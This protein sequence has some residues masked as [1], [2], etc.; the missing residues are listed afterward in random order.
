[1]AKYYLTI[2]LSIL[3]FFHSFAG[4]P[5]SVQTKALL[6]GKLA[7]NQFVL[8][9][10]QANL[11]IRVYNLEGKRIPCT[12]L[13]FKQLTTTRYETGYDLNQGVYVVRVQQGEQVSYCKLIRRKS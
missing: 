12:L 5:D 11:D 13:K 9:T 4:L 7:V 2:L 8:E 6:S 3:P 1:M 10:D